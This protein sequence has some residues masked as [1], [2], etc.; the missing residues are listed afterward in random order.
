MKY[1][2][3]VYGSPSLV[4]LTVILLWNS[5]G[6]G[7]AECEI[8]IPY[9]SWFICC[10]LVFSVLPGWFYLQVLL[11][12][13][14]L[15]R[16]QWQQKTGQANQH[17]YQ[18]LCNNGFERNVYAWGAS[19]MHLHRCCIFWYFAYILWP[20]TLLWGNRPCK[21]NN[22]QDGNCENLKE[23]VYTLLYVPFPQYEPSLLKEVS[24][25]NLWI[26]SQFSKRVRC[27]TV[28]GLWHLL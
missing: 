9:S 27:Y 10:H 23:N 17:W 24:R 18:V 2:W 25:M 16:S 4:T 5:V 26:L 8:G 28:F 11:R 7:N 6:F 19:S 13:R 14:Y 12:G 15:N 21:I 22:W 3:S 1:L 20:V